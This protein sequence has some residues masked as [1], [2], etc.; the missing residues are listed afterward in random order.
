MKAKADFKVITDEEM[1]TEENMRAM[2]Y[3]M[4][5]NRN[6][7]EDLMNCD[8]FLKLDDERSK[9]AEKW[10]MLRSMLENKMERIWAQISGT[11][12]EYQNST[13]RRRKHFLRLRAKDEKD[14]KLIRYQ[15]RKI[16]K[17]YVSLGHLV[18]L[19]FR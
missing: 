2:L 3:Q 14:T 13:E 7:D 9:N 18:I 6:R 17:L 19:S 5:M 16:Q 8:M 11:L 1:E 4:E 10:E 12:M 15:T